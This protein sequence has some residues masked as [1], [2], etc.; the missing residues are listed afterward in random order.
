ME[1]F[2]FHAQRA[3]GKI[4]KALLVAAGSEFC[5]THRIA[6]LIDELEGASV[7]LPEHFN[8]LRLLT[9]YAVDF[10]Y[11]ILPPEREQPIDI[12]QIRQS[13]QELRNYVE[14]HVEGIR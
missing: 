4:L 6:E 9:P 11:E 7:D 8:E 14:S 5:R 3:T 2:G 1:A 13:I 12:G 10:R